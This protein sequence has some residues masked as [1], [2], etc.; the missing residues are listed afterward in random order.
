MQRV[1]VTIF[2]MALAAAG[3]PLYIHLPRFASGELGLNLATIGVLLISIRVLDFVQDPLLGWMIDRWPDLA[4]AFGTIALVGMALGF[5]SL[6]SFS[7]PISPEIWLVMSLVLLFTSYSLGSIL[8]Y[9]Q[10]VALAGGGSHAELYSLAGYRE[11]G[12]ILGIL[13]ATIAPTVL[14]A[15]GSGYAAFGMLLCLFL[16]GVTLFTRNMWQDSSQKN[17][18]FVLTDLRRQDIRQLL[19]LAL[20]NSL[21]VAI[22]STLFLFFVEDRLLLANMAGPFLLLFFIASGVS[23]PVWT[24]LVHSNGARR[25]LIPAMCLAIVSFIGAALLPSGSVAPFA[26]ICVASGAALGADMV[27]LPVLFTAALQRANLQAGQAF[28]LWS[29][30]IK[31]ALA[32]AAVLVLP[33]LNWAGF[34]AGAENSLIALNALT[35]TYAILPC[36]IKAAAIWFLLR[37]P[38]EVL[39]Q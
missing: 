6:F 33:L 4:K 13:F 36:G 21:P 9:C 12:A 19:L 28:G 14:I 22:T 38:S 15:F 3:L 37:L 18:R 30:T 35:F 16:L 29:F 5:L 11:G 17:T 20:I 27:V 8:F 26:L 23:V 1:Q 34:Q 2:S 7:A 32:L 39:E 31:L 10:T 24:K 25:V